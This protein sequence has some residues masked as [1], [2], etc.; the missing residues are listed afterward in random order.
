MRLTWK[1]L[2]SAVLICIGLTCPAHDV[3]NV[4]FG[5]PTLREQS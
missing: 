4:A 2:I 5:V 1:V 3:S